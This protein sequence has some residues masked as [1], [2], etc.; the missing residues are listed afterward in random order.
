MIHKEDQS[1]SI[2]GVWITGRSFAGSIHPHMIFIIKTS[3]VSATILQ[4]IDYS[5]LDGSRKGSNSCTTDLSRLILFMWS[6]KITKDRTTTLVS[7][8]F[9][10]SNHPSFHSRCL[11]LHWHIIIITKSP[12]RL[13]HNLILMNRCMQPIN[14]HLYI[15]YKV[16]IYWLQ[17]SPHNINNI[18]GEF[19]ESSVVLG[20]EPSKISWV[21]TG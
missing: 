5:I 9:F 8:I 11:K 16:N 10:F 19:Y 1:W 14:I 18:W 21:I 12:Q 3:V 15:I 20:A 7:C 2:C 4:C 17:Y 6:R 13:D